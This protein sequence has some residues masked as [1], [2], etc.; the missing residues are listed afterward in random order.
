M[1]SSQT[2]RAKLVLAWIGGLVLAWLALSVNAQELA[3]IPPFNGL[4][5]DL[6]G[7]LGSQQKAVLENQLRA[8]QARKGSQ[9]AILLV[10]STRP[11]SIEEYAVRVF[12]NWQIGRQGIDDGVLFVVAK[13]DHR[14]RIEVGYG[15]EGALPDATAKRIISEIVTPRFR[16]DDFAGGI[17]QGADQILR[18]IDGEPLPPPKQ[19]T[20]GSDSE[21][22][23]FAA[24]MVAVFLGFLLRSAFGPLRGSGVAALLSGG[25]AWWLSL[26]LMVGVLG[27]LVG[28]LGCLLFG[29]GGG[30]GFGGG[31]GGSRS[32][33][34]GSFG[35][36]GGGLSGGGGAS[37]SW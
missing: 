8:F 18:V 15:L 29:N 23:L 20:N 34:G 17:Q 37:G 26:S 1:S 4:V 33:G 35:G 25:I 2:W 30:G 5:T 36:G 32:G 13:N 10:P 22:A 12:E 24:F 31:F 9:V 14:L 11:E 27:A 19:R 6:T 3:A 16:A 7:T 28:F 21:H